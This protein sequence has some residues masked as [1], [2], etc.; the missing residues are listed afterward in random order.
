[1]WRSLRLPHISNRRHGRPCPGHPRLS[2]ENR[3]KD[4]DARDKRGHD[5]GKKTAFACSGIKVTSGV[6]ST[7]HA[8][9]PTGAGA[10]E[11]ANSAAQTRSEAPSPTLP[12]M[13]GREKA[14]LRLARSPVLPRDAVI[15]I[16]FGKVLRQFVTHRELTGRRDPPGIDEP[17][18]LHFQ[19]KRSWPYDE[20]A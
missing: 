9:S 13:R 15:P 16:K 2:A 11:G 3:E 12:R 14:S 17:A 20:L 7:A 6:L 10:G 5:A 18:S 8:P 19:G 4:V 1:M